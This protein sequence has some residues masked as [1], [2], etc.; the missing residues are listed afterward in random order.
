[1]QQSRYAAGCLQVDIAAQIMT[2]LMI[3][4]DCRLLLR[5][6]LQ[7]QHHGKPM[8]VGDTWHLHRIISIQGY[9]T[10]F[11][12]QPCTDLPEQLFC[13]CILLR[14]VPTEHPHPAETDIKLVHQ[15][16]QEEPCPHTAQYSV[17][18]LHH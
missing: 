8:A 13:P 2:Q 6:A 18:P 11:H 15:Q 14:N 5:I 17:Y 1:M 3:Q 9:L 10:F 4:D 12:S 16:R 7:R